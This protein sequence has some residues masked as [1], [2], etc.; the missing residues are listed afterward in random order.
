MVL[1]VAVPRDGKALLVRSISQ[2]SCF[3]TTQH[4]APWQVLAADGM[5]ALPK[6]KTSHSTICVSRAAVEALVVLLL[7]IDL[8]HRLLAHTTAE[9]NVK[10]ILVAY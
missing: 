10:R 8:R 6:P 9:H 2:D 3:A 1:E 4:T 5:A 7:C